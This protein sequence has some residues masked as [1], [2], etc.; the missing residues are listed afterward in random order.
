MIRPATIRSPQHFPR[1]LPVF[2]LHPD[3]AEKHAAPRLPGAQDSSHGQAFRAAR[4]LATTHLPR[5]CR[6]HGNG[7]VAPALCSQPVSIC[8]AAVTTIPASFDGGAMRPR[9]RASR[10]CTRLARCPT[11][12]HYGPSTAVAVGRQKHGQKPSSLARHLE[13]V[14]LQS[15]RRRQTSRERPL[16]FLP[17]A[18]VEEPRVAGV[19]TA[20]TAPRMGS[21]AK[22]GTARAAVKTGE[23]ARVREERDMAVEAVPLEA[24]VALRGMTGAGRSRDGGRRHTCL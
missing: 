6:L 2:P 8:P 12:G 3:P 18:V 21:A 24:A 10:R 20:G 22:G 15:P 17:G 5:P 16:R 23:E 11:D 4:S 14:G 1:L 13:M 7:D 9:T 19:A